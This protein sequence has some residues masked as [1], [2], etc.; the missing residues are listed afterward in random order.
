MGWLWLNATQDLISQERIGG[1]YFNFVHDDDIIPMLAALGIYSGHNLL[2]R[3]RNQED[4]GRLPHLPTDRIES[5]R[6]WRTNGLVLMGGRIII[7]QL[8]CGKGTDLHQSEAYIRFIINDGIVAVRGDE[9]G[10]MTTVANFQ[11]LLRERGE[12]VGDFE[13]MCGLDNSAPSRITFI[14]Q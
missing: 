4:V 1:V 12:A 11:R 3:E 10:G 13:E 5:K 6:L 7:E 2:Q 8:R 14:H 9:Y